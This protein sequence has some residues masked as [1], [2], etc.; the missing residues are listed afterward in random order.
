VNNQIVKEIKRNG[1][2]RLLSVY[3]CISA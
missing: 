2:K 1:E 3:M